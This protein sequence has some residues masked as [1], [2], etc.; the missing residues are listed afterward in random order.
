MRACPRRCVVGLWRRRLKAV[1]ATLA[2]LLLAHLLLMRLRVLRRVD[3][4][5]G[6]WAVGQVDRW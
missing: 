2:V 1:T 4:V 6:R 5:H 3:V